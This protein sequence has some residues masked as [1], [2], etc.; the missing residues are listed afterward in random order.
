MSDIIDRFIPFNQRSISSDTELVLTDQ[1]KNQSEIIGLI[2]DYI[3]QLRLSDLSQ[4]TIARYSQCLHSYVV[5]L[6]TGY[7]PSEYSARLFLG[8]LRERGLSQRSVA[9]Y[10]YAIR[11][12]LESQG[13]HI[14]VK[15][16]RRR[17]LPPYHS[18][19]Q[20]SAILAAV[21][22]RRD[23]WRKVK[24][25]DRAA[26]YTLAYTGMRRSELLSLTKRQ[27]DFNTRT[28]RVIGK[29][30][31]ERIIPIA[32]Y[33]YDILYPYCQSVTTSV[34]FPYSH[35]RLR[36]MI[37]YYCRLAGV[38]HLHPHSFRHF[39][40]TQLVNS[41]VPLHVCQELLGHQDIATTA[42]YLDLNPVQLQNAVDR[43]P[44]FSQK[45]FKL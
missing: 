4:L 43:L 29:G 13:I 24:V 12:F 21:E 18:V 37:N 11:P 41:G 17:R 6:G 8:E 32:G 14:K 38:D 44:D 5:F 39:F 7:Q 22:G 45:G 10:Y 36:M 34:L 25:R 28:I 42:I 3:A 16:K 9:I 20:I 33:F 31:H 27:I 26:L 15:F 19:D 1:I 35:T 23:N 30:D 40:A 2:S